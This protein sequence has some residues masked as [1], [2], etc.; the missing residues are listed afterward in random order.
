MLLVSVTAH[1]G[2]Q[3]HL[4]LRRVVGR[5]AE[6]EAHDLPGSTLINNDIL[7][8]QVAMDHLYTRVEEGQAL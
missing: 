6:V 7:K 3:P 2:N 8:A 4:S 5:D 1:S